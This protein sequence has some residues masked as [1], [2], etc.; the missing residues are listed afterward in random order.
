MPKKGKKNIRDHLIII[1]ILK[2]RGL[3]GSGIIGAYH[4]RRVMPLMRCTLPQ[5]VMVPG[6]S[7]DGDGAC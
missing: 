6:A 7:F 2:E 4:A 1:R 3:K 5:Y